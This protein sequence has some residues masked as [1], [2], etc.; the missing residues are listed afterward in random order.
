[1][2][3]NSLIKGRRVA[4]K[5]FLMEVVQK[6]QQFLLDNRS[7]A[8]TTALTTAGVKVPPEVSRFYDWAATPDAGP[9]PTFT[10]RVTPKA[11]TRQDGDGWMEINEAGAKS[12]E[13]PGKTDWK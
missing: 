10:V 6:E 13:F 8:D 9:P 2:Y 1:S 7:Y 12:A 4:A 11:G 5:A 3:Q